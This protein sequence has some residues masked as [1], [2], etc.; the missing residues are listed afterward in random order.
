MGDKITHPKSACLLFRIIS[1]PT[2]NEYKLFTDSIYKL[3]YR[4]LINKK[5]VIVV[6]YTVT[7][8]WILMGNINI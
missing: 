5:I 7:I 4:M 3:P 1:L 6:E 8:I 2:W